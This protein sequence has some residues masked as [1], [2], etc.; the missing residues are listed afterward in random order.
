M[1]KGA[2][3]ADGGEVALGGEEG[4]GGVGYEAVGLV[5]VVSL[6]LLLVYVMRYVGISFVENVPAVAASLDGNLLS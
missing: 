1:A 2:V 6:Y 5:V 4:G 3:A